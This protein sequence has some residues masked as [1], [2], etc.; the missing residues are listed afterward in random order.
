[1][2]YGTAFAAGFDLDT[3]SEM[4]WAGPFYIYGVSIA[5]ILFSGFLLILRKP[6]I[7]AGSIRFP[8]VASTVK[9]EKEGDGAT[10][11]VNP[12]ISIG[13]SNAF[14]QN[15]L[16][17]TLSW[18]GVSYSQPALKRGGVSVNLLNES[19]GSSKPRCITAV[20][21]YDISKEQSSA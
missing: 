20:V 6:T 18:T 8:F 10:A 17:L 21:S 1:M 3:R 4:M 16:P 2:R 11:T 13:E 14:P 12:A 9:V 5:A 19:H 15:D 7:T